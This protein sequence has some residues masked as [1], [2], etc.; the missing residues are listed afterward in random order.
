MRESLPGQGVQLANVDYVADA[1]VVDDFLLAD[2][3]LRNAHG[4]GV[5]GHILNLKVGALCMVV[6]NLNIS[7]GLVNGTKVI[8]V[9]I[10]HRVVTVRR[11]GETEH[12]LIQEKL[13]QKFKFPLDTGCPVEVCRRQFPLRICYAMSAHKSQGQTIDIVGCDFR[14]S[15][16]CH[17]L[18]YVTLG[19]VRSSEHI[20]ILV[21]ERS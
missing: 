4:K 13:E 3:A 12:L 18:L 9:A 19:R 1:D 11:P 20:R 2:E 16:F 8:I 17:G 10:A 21:N 6:R 14:S 15:P 7:D 5:R